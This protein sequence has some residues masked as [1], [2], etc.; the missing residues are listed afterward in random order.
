MFKR[1][2]VTGGAGFIGSHLARSLV[3]EQMEVV[4]LDNLSMGK[5]ENIPEGAEFVCGDVRSRDDV[6][7]VLDDVDIV[8]HEAARVSIRS[9]VGDFYD[10]A[11]NNLMGTINL[12]S[13]CSDSCVKKVI[14]ASSMAV[15]AD[16][17]EPK[18]ISE[19]YTLEPISPYGISKLACEKYC[20]RFSETSGVDCHVLRY[21]NTYGTGQS[22]TPYVGVIT[23]FI[24]NLFD[25][26]APVIFGDGQQKR[27]FTHVSDIVSANILSMESDISRGT[28]NVGTGMKTSV[29]DIAKI[30]CKKINPD[31]EPVYGDAQ[32]GELRYSIAGINKARKDLGYCPK[33]KLADRIDEVIEYYKQLKTPEIN[34]M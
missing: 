6:S 22:F 17:Q 26:K 30:L 31:I 23:I 7:K 5:A 24:N 28:F 33:V 2:L 14:F 12:L 8:F 16:C 18:P 27:D 21:F 20:M 25:G 13:C 3:S 19:D 34:A 10:D 1:A 32:S 4:V 11:D 15:Y 29:N 9:S